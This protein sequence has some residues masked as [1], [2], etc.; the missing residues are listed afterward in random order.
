[1]V[2]MRRMTRENRNDGKYAHGCDGK[3]AQD[4]QDI[5]KA[6]TRGAHLRMDTNSVVSIETWPAALC[7]RVMSLNWFQYI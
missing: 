2:N 1:M 3:Y 7:S 4:D 5:K 6:P